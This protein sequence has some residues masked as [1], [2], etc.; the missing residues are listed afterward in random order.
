M[1]V[2]GGTRNANFS[3]SYILTP[4][5]VTTP[6]TLTLSTSSLTFTYSGTAL[7]TQAVQVTSSGAPIPVTTSV[8]TASGGNWLT[9]TPP[10]G[11]TPLPVTVGVN[12]A[13]LV[14][15][16]LHGHRHNCLHGRHR[17]PQTVAVT[18]NGTAV[19]PPTLPTLVLSSAALDFTPPVGGT[20]VPKSV[21]VTS[22]DSSAVV[23]TAAAATK[24]GGNWLSVS[25]TTASTPSAEMISVA[26]TG[27]AAG[28]YSGTVTFSSSGASNTPVLLSVTLNGCLRRHL[29]HPRSAVQLQRHGPAVRR[30][31]QKQIARGRHGF[32]RLER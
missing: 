23:F 11:S 2:T 8:S 1:Y 10:G 24:S 3:N 29:R 27:L 6:E 19:T 32:G 16:N 28:T 15:G 14:G 9:A 30:H 26:L 5:A 4:A 22:S 31:Q 7:A 20:A 17:S 21:Q 25:L 18:L 12:P 13:G